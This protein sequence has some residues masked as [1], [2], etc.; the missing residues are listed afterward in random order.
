MDTEFGHFIETLK[1]LGIQFQI[2]WG[3]TKE[4]WQQ[5]ISDAG[6]NITAFACTVITV[7]EVDYLFSNGPVVWD[8]KDQSMGPAGL[9]LFCRK[10][11]GEIIPRALYRYAD[12]K[13]MPEQ[14]LSAIKVQ[15]PADWSVTNGK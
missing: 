13:L 9:F 3:P 8:E 14:N 15:Y 2:N 12:N 1:R 5:S 7:A 11:S 6:Y 10:R 4:N